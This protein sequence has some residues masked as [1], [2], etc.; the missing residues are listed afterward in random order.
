MVAIG[1]N[2]LLV[3]GCAL[4][5][6]V[7]LIAG[8]SPTLSDYDTGKKYSELRV[9]F[10]IECIKKNTVGAIEARNALQKHSPRE[11]ITVTRKGMAS[12]K[13]Q[14]E[15]VQGAYDALVGHD[16]RALSV[17]E[18]FEKLQ[19][20]QLFSLYYR[21][22]AELEL[23]LSIMN[24]T[25]F[26]YHEIMSAGNDANV[27]HEVTGEADAEMV[28]ALKKS[29]VETIEFVNTIDSYCF[30]NPRVICDDECDMNMRDGE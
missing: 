16:L 11:G 5:S 8:D 19:M 13:N 26:D 3:A 23:F 25:A 7:S 2:N 29:I 15:W 4:L 28:Q 14:N 22:R 20:V 24:G 12:G 1:K 9:K 21:E 18:G 10:I 17:A 27:L 30:P 6:C